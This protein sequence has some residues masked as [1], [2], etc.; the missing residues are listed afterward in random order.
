MNTLA[1]ADDAQALCEQESPRASLMEPD[2][3]EEFTFLE[4]F[5]DDLSPW[6]VVWT[7]LSIDATGVVTRRD[8][9][10]LDPTDFAG[11]STGGVFPYDTAEPDGSG[12]SCALHVVR[13]NGVEVGRLRDVGCLLLRRFVCERDNAPPTTTQEPTTAAITA[14]PLFTYTEDGYALDSSTKRAYK[15]FNLER[16]TFAGAEQSCTMDAAGAHLAAPV[17]TEQKESLQQYLEAASTVEVVW[18]GGQVNSM[19]NTFTFTTGEAPGAFS[20]NSSSGVFVTQPDGGPFEQDEP[21][22]GGPACL[23]NVLAASAWRDIDC[24]K[25]RAYVCQVVVA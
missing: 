4:A 24:S 5:L 3:A 17:T 10:N 11:N 15:V 19:E 18:I 7:G 20:Y 1:T 12:R 25:P 23:L 6:D 2:S 22:L 9:V 13:L 8:G 21:N 14:A 16:S